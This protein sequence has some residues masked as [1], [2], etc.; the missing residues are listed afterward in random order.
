MISLDWFCVGKIKK[1]YSFCQQIK[2]KQVIIDR[3]C[4]ENN[5]MLAKKRIIFSS[6]NKNPLP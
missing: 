3:F 2:Y 4:N 1:N 5:R 6:G